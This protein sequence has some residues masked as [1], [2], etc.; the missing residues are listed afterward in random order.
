MLARIQ[1]RPVPTSEP[2]AELWFGAHPL[3]PSS[4]E[5]EGIEQ[6]LDG[7]LR[8][9]DTEELG[10]DVVHRFGKLPFLLKVLAVEQ[11]LSI[12]VHPTREQAQSGFDRERAS[13][14]VAQCPEANYHD[15]W[16]KPELLC[17]LTPFEALCGFRPVAEL[18]ELMGE[19]GGE[20]FESAATTL[21]RAPNGGGLRE[22]VTH[23]L[24]ANGAPRARLY[25][26]ALEAC[27]RAQEG[28][29]ECD[30]A[31][32]ALELAK[33][34]PGDMGV[35]VALLLQHW[36]LS[37]GMGLFVPPGVMHAY[38]KG[39]AVEVMATSDNVLR[40][41]LTSKHVDV[42]E[43]LTVLNFDAAPIRPTPVEDRGP[44]EAAFVA[45][46][47]YYRVS[48]I[49]VR[50]HESYCARRRM[51]PEMVLCVEGRLELV[52]AQNQQLGLAQGECGWISANEDVYCVAGLGQGF[53]VQVGA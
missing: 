32:V 23:W 12:Q 14:V 36:S 8:K 49:D 7:Y 15:E 40:G 42:T 21:V 37:P 52:G 48:R 38:L 51:G 17:P 43:L 25:D 47:E 10:I 13:G 46:C 1:G 5:V 28:S 29:T 44:L 45:D 34:Y 9:H 39:L 33:R 24:N 50:P 41:G 35:L 53:R 4:I 11:P 27:A 22:V 16:P 18:V 20:C 2:E 26:S 3:S 19:L 30:S 6:T 31:V